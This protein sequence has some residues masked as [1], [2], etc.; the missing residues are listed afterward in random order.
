LR[1]VEARA[2]GN[3]EK[4]LCFRGVDPG[5]LRAYSSLHRKAGRLGEMAGLLNRRTVL[6]LLAAALAHPRRTG[7]L[8]RGTAAADSIIVVAGW[9]LRGDDLEKVA[10]YAA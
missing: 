6:W 4:V 1:P 10:P 8:P 2:F 3:P 7:S 9:I 5:L